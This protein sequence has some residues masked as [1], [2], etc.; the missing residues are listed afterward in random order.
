MILCCIV[1]RCHICGKPASIF[2]TK[3]SDGK[4]TDL[5]LCKD[6]AREKGIFDPRKLTLAEQLFPAEISGEVEAFIKKM[7]ESSYMED[8]EADIHDSLPDM[9]T[10]CPVC[11]FT[12]ENYQQTGFVGCPECY[13]VFSSELA[14][15]LGLPHAASASARKV[16][17]P[18]YLDSPVLERGRLEVLMQEAIRDE[19]YEEAAALRDRIKNLPES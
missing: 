4:V 2:L 18:D 14:S 15:A 19:N 11:H 17:E 7:I 9:L 1:K 13:K 10:E 16:V 12:L 5:A 3:I 8:A 6:C